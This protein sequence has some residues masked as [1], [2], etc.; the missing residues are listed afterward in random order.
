VRLHIHITVGFALVS[1]VFAER[2]YYTKEQKQWGLAASAVLTRRNDRDLY[3]LRGVPDTELER[4]KQKEFLVDNGWDVVSREDLLATM[5]RL[6]DGG[7]RASVERIRFQKNWPDFMKFVANALGVGASDYRRKFV[8]ERAEELEGKSLTGWDLSRLISLARWGVAAGYLEE[9]EA[10]DWIMPAAVEIQQTY[11]SW[12]DLGESYLL[13]RE[14]WSPLQTQATGYKYRGAV[15]W[16]THNK[17][18]PWKNFD[19]NMDL[20]SSMSPIEDDTPMPKT[21]LYYAADR[22][23]GYGK[24]NEAM[25]ILLEAKDRG[26]AL[27][28]GSAL[29]RLGDYLTYGRKGIA[30]DPQQGIAYYE[31]GA[32][33]SHAGCLL[34]LG[35]VYYYGRGRDKDYGKAFE[36][37]SRGAELGS[38][39]CLDNLGI[40]YQEGKGV[41][42]DLKK[43]RELYESAHRYGAA[44]ALNSIAWMMFKNDGVW[45]PD[46][47]VEYAY[48]A[49]R[50]WEC[51]EHYDTLVKVLI[52]A[53][54]WDEASV[55]LN[56]WERLNMRQRNNYDPLALPPKFK[57]L[58]KTIDQARTKQSSN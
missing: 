33:L 32:R 48:G 39:A 36:L 50:Q 27:S 31:E 49:I 6:R 8:E 1:G 14:F 52:K 28:R 11:V 46:E 57:N 23:A 3:S 19:W 16:L 34:E 22:L 17:Y 12:E 9:D 41:E 58:H 20:G 53:E 45:D 18:S 44:G 15:Y 4:G 7:H 25:G 21:E 54:R 10:W 29:E 2:L 26:S 56:Q 13:G 30:K 38:P 5:A 40:L 43:A 47:A 35:L 37:W 24:H 42:K 51:G 55:Q